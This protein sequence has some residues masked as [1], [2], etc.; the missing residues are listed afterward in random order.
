MPKSRFTAIVRDDENS[1]YYD[2]I[3]SAYGA[4]DVEDTCRAFLYDKAIEEGSIEAGGGESLPEL[5]SMCDIVAVFAG[6]HPNL[7]TPDNISI[8][9]LV[10]PD[11]YVPSKHVPEE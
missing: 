4:D 9:R 8:E 5:S 7:V 2:I 11:N 6:D 1:Q 10:I 3:L